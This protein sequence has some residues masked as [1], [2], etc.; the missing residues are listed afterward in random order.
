MFGSGGAPVLSILAGTI[1]LPALALLGALGVQL[2]GKGGSFLF[3]VL[4]LSFV[5]YWLA[6][7]SAFE[8][9]SRTS[10]SRSV[11]RLELGQP[12]TPPTPIDERKGGS[13]PASGRSGENGESG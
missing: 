9:H 12:V 2:G 11:I 13:R 10:G 7:W 5:F 1:A 8:I 3:V 6:L 4:A